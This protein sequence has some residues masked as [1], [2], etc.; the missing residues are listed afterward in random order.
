MVTRIYLDE[1]SVE[2]AIVPS[3]GESWI[4]DIKLK[5]F[6]LRLFNTKSGTAKRFCIRTTDA[7]GKPVRKTYDILEARHQH[8]AELR[9]PLI[10]SNEVLEFDWNLPVSKY[11][12]VARIW[13]RNE[14]RALK[15]LKTI[16]RDD[17]ERQTYIAERLGKTTLSDAV[18]AVLSNYRKMRLSNTY[19]DKLD[20]LFFTLVPVE[21]RERSMAI[22]SEND[23]LTIYRCI[24]SKI[25]NKRTIMPFLGRV[26]QIYQD[27]AGGRNQ[28]AIA[29]YIMRRENRSQKASFSINE[30]NIDRVKSIISYLEVQQVRWQQA[31][32]LRLYLK[33][34]APL[35]QLMSARW[36]QLY[37]VTSSKSGAKWLEWRYGKKRFGYEYIKDREWHFLQLVHKNVRENFVGSDFWFP[38]SFGRRVDHI[39]TVDDFWHE[40]LNEVGLKYVSP[41]AMRKAIQNISPYSL[42]GNSTSNFSGFLR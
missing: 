26:F 27:L 19:I 12:D 14:I 38:S 24:V 1:A 9:N 39:R 33:M 4:S 11:T 40:A 8:Y 41:K 6:G 3:K 21:L 20:K 2:N 37:D 42:F 16:E 7:N 28:F 13:A 17:H 10:F 30:A 34:H 5:G 18:Q 35:S 32:C 36:D 29:K 15:G 31:L 25:G 22:I 23:A